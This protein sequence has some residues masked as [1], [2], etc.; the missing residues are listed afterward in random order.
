[1]TWF[2]KLLLR[3]KEESQSRSNSQKRREKHHSSV[4]STDHNLRRNEAKT[5]QVSSHQKS[6]THSR[7]QTALTNTTRPSSVNQRRVRRRRNAQGN[8]AAVNPQKTLVAQELHEEPAE[9]RPSRSES[10]SRG[11]F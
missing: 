1:M 6:V 3:L 2:F 4:Q 8:Q 11:R 10:S 9:G 7:P 5:G